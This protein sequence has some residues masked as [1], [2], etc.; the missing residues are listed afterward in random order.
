MVLL[1][2]R[3]A[4]G[5][6]DGWMD[7]SSIQ[8]SHRLASTHRFLLIKSNLTQSNPVSQRKERLHD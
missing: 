8:V 2:H 3:Q 4:S 6:M 1:A 7:R 5:G